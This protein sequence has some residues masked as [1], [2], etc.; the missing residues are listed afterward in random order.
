MST[1]LSTLNNLSPVYSDNLKLTVSESTASSAFTYIFII[2]LNTTVIDTFRYFADP[3]TFNAII[4]LSPILS[5]YFTSEIYTPLGDVIESISD[6]IFTYSVAVTTY[7]AS[8]QVV[9]TANTGNKYVFNGCEDVQDNFDIDDFIFQTGKTSNF[10]TNWNTNRMIT[11]NDKAYLNTIIGNYT[12]N[13]SAFSGIEVTRYQSDNTISSVEYNN[14]DNTNKRII[15]LDVSPDTI[16]IINSNF[17]NSDT[18]Y[19]TIKELND[20]EN[21]I[22]RI[23]IIQK[24]KHTDYYNF[25]YMN[26]LGGIDFISAGV[27]PIE[28]IKIKKE[29][30]DHY[31]TLKVYNISSTNEIIVLTE[32]LTIDQFNYLYN[33]FTSPAVEVYYET[34]LSSINITNRKIEK[35]SKYPKSD[36]LRRV[37]EFEFNNKKYIQQ[38]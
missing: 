1:T 38:F 8:N 29:I 10:L 34:I 33:L 9:D 36:M 30:L 19:Y 21:V 13:V 7:N 5:K 28:E 20:R 6:S 15:N 18:L 26:K 23:N 31:E 22:M 32:L 24:Y 27:S 4:D 37:I 11:I 16:N 14:T 2:T 35:I 25:L 3:I 17:L 12:T